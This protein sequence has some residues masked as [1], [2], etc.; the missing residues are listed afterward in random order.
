MSLTAITSVFG[1][2]SVPFVVN[3][4]LVH[5]GGQG[6][7][8]DLPV[9]RMTLGVFVV[10]TLPLILAMSL[11][12]R[13]PEESARVEKLARHVATILFA[14]I[15]AGA[16]ASQWRTMM[17]HAGD[18]LPPALAINVGAMALA[19]LVGRV[20]RLERREKLAVVLEPGCRTGPLGI[21]IAAHLAGLAGHD[22]PQH[23]LRPGDER[24]R[25]GGDRLGQGILRQRK[26]R[27]FPRLLPKVKPVRL[28]FQT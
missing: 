5:V 23:R 7:T 25:V 2:L 4:A 13:W 8:V 21:F 26:R 24:P 1:A 6:G 27:G 10:A 3:L 9:A 18:V 11:N 14:F 16:F 12:H 28:T 17:T 20:G 22:G 15:V 19:W